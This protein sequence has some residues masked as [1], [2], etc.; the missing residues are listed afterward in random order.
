MNYTTGSYS[1]LKMNGKRYIIRDKETK[2]V[3]YRNGRK[4][5][6]SNI[7]AAIN[8]YAD[9]N[10]GLKNYYEI[11]DSKLNIVSKAYEGKSDKNISPSNKRIMNIS[12]ERYS[13]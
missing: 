9:I 10:F 13:I 5:E 6:F 1:P 12:G 8:V 11:F 4:M 3:K 2:K 7:S